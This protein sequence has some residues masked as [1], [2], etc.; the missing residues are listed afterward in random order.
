M[1]HIKF[2]SCVCG[3]VAHASRFEISVYI[4]TDIVGYVYYD[5][6][7]ADT[8][9]KMVNISDIADSDIKKLRLTRVPTE[10]PHLGVHVRES[11]QC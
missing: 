11:L 2:V 7:I 1:H 6:D 8:T 3:C 9:E 5:T 10:K 4:D